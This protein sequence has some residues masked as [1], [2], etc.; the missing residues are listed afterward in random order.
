MNLQ[1]GYEG[2]DWI[3]LAQDRVQ[4]HIFV[5]HGDEP[6]RFVKVQNFLTS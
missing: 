5:N 4:W 6:L 3:Q 1:K 2:F